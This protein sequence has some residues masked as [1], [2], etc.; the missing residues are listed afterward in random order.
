MAYDYLAQ[1]SQGTKFLPFFKFLFFWLHYYSMIHCE[2]VVSIMLTSFRTKHKVNTWYFP[3]SLLLKR[4]SFHQH[5][6]ALWGVKGIRRW[7]LCVTRPCEHRENVLVFICTVFPCD[8]AAF[9]TIQG[10]CFSVEEL[11]CKNAGQTPINCP[12]PPP[13]PCPQT[14]P[15]A[16][17]PKTR[18]SGE[19]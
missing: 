9:T 10:H 18:T 5:N 1:P 13:P 11:H 8:A 19:Q 2:S 6:G 17:P 16:G 12:P 14:T 15:S 3:S 7:R 4:A